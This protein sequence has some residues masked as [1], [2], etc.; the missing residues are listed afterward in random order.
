MGRNQPKVLKAFLI[1]VTAKAA[2]LFPV[3]VL[4]PVSALS[5]IAG[6]WPYNPNPAGLFLAAAC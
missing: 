4:F 1:K 5:E 2:S 6:S 3:L